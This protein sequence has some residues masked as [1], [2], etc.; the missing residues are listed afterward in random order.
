MFVWERVTF[1]SFEKEKNALQAHEKLSDKNYMAKK[2]SY[3]ARIGKFLLNFTTDDDIEPLSKRKKKKKCKNL[4]ER[5]FVK[6]S[7]PK[8]GKS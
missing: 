6:Q 5:F 2:L 3:Y 8:N 1:S 7:C 4:F